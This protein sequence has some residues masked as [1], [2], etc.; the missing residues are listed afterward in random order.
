MKYHDLFIIFEKSTEFEIVGGTLLVNEPVS[1][2]RFELECA[3]SK[4]S[5]QFS[6]QHSLIR[7]LSST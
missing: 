7:A 4:D 3:Y 1:S 2:I 5:N 6:H